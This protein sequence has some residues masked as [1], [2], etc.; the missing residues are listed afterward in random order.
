AP[1]LSAIL[2]SLNPPQRQAAEHVNGAI[3][4]LAGAG[5]GKTKVLTTRLANLIATGTASPRNILSVTFTNKAAKEMAHRVEAIIGTSTA[6]MWMGTFHSIGARLLRTHAERVGLKPDFTILDTDDQKRLLD[7]ILKDYN[8]DTTANP[9]RLLAGIISRWKDNAWMPNDVPQAEDGFAGAHG[10]P[11]GIALYAEYQKRLQA[12]NATDF[13]D[14]LLLPVQLFKKHP[15]V[16]EHYQRQLTHVLVD[17]Y[18]DTNTV[19]YLWLRLLTMTNKNLCVVGDDDQ[20]IYGWRGAQVGNILRFE[21][22]FPGTTVVRLEQN[23]RS[24]GVILQAASQLIANNKERHGKTLWTQGNNG[25]LIELHPMADDREESRMVADA[26]EHHL[27]D[28][29]HYADCAVLVRTAAQTRSLEEQFIKNNTPYVVVGGMKFY[30][31]KE[32]RDAI[33]YLRLIAN[34]A[35]SLA[36]ERIINVPRR[37]VGDGALQQ[38]QQIAREQ[39]IP[40]LAATFQ[41]VQ[42]GFLTGKAK[43]ALATLTDH[44][45]IWQNLQNAQTPDRLLEQVLTE[46][47]YLD[48]L[49]QDKDPETKT[50][51]DNLKELVRA[52]QDYATLGEFLEHVSL[53]MDGDD[54]TDDAVRLMTIHAAKGLEFDTVFLPGFEDG[55]FP[56]VR[57]LNESG[58]KGIEEERRLA[59]V[60]ITR[61]KRRL[62]ISYAS[63]R[64][65][66]GQFQPSIA[67]RFLAEIPEECLKVHLSTAPSF[68]TYGGN[69]GSSYGSHGGFRSNFSSRPTVGSRMDTRTNTDYA[70]PAEPLIPYSAVTSVSGHNVG[71]RVFHQKFG[72]GRIQKMEGA[73]DDQRLTITFDKAGPKT[74]LASLA[75]LDVA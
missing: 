42:H 19:Q 18:Q 27:R 74:L 40:L 66:Y 56:H 12:L 61:A 71:D 20:S 37:G 72:Y 15:D 34:P 45:A 29:G 38:L 68:N 22:D 67:S 59:Y 33:A 30:E 26:C 43:S 41:A 57:S 16:L 63:S 35:D 11:Q 14:L 36:F 28:G 24:T 70:K 39:T 69:Y 1:D 46:S 44:I 8:I 54:N 51:I 9:P 73:G 23:Y 25:E 6:G 5:T 4:V 21:T 32:V 7:Q 10:R 64:R 31:R 58:N 52:L 2:A 47:G 53:V 65:M 55:I 75:K 3:W 50:R 62:V 17:E 49:H 13:G 60:A 48:M